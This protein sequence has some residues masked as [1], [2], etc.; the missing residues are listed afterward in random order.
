MRAVTA[1]QAA[2]LVLAGLGVLAATQ[3]RAQGAPAGSLRDRESRLRIVEAPA[4]RLLP[5]APSSQLTTTG[6]PSA[7]RDARGPQTTFRLAEVAPARVEITRTV[8]RELAVRQ[9]PE[10]ALVVTLPADVLF[11]FDSASL[12]PD[13]LAA[14]DRTAELLRSY[15]RAALEIHGH[16]DAKGTDAYNDSL[17]QRRAQAVATRLAPHAGGRDLAVQGFGE[18]RPVAANAQ[19]D[20]S[21]DPAG[22]QRNRRVEIVIQPLR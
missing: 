17:S 16:T 4:T 9:T 6:R 2:A 7:L 19:P 13:A 22:R 3:V 14:V 10:Q 18:R 12:R 20:G 15:E 1:V 21:D 11:D 8:L 5:A